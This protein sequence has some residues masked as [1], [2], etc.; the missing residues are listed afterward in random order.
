MINP[1]VYAMCSDSAKRCDAK[2]TAK[3]ILTKRA[4]VVMAPWNSRR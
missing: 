3:R 1:C 2:R 4:F